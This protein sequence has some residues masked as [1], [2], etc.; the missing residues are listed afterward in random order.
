M[1]SGYDLLSWTFKL[2]GFLA[3]ISLIW[4]RNNLEICVKYKQNVDLIK[5]SFS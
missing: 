4:S 1:E 3:I 5:N 2:Q